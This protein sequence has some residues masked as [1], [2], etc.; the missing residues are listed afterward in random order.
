MSVSSLEDP[1]SSEPKPIP[2]SAGTLAFFSR[3]FRTVRVYWWMLACI[4]GAVLVQVA[5]RL[6]L[7]LA[8]QRLIDDA[9]L[10]KEP[11]LVVLVSLL[12]GGWL[13]QLGAS[14]F[15]DYI[16]A[17]MW[18]K[19]MN[20]LRLQLFRQIQRLSTSFFVRTDANQL[21][22]RFADDLLY[23]ENVY[24]QVIF[25]VILNTLLVLGGSLLLMYLEWQLALLALMVLPIALLMPRILGFSARRHNRAHETCEAQVAAIMRES[26]DGNVVVRTLGLQ[27]HHQTL[28]QTHLEELGNKAISSYFATFRMERGAAQTLLLIQLIVIGIGSYFASFG[29]LSLGGLVAFGALY[30]QL[31]NSVS[32]LLASRILLNR[33]SQGL[34]RLDEFLAEEPHASQP[35]VVKPVPSLSRALNLERICFG[36]NGHRT[37]LENL[38]LKLLAGESL[39]IVGPKGSGKSSVLNLVLR[40]Y[41]P[42]SGRVMVDDVELNR[43]TEESFRAQT[44]VVTQQTFLFNTSFHNNI[45][46]GKLDATQEE[47]VQA[48]REAEIH[49]TIMA[50]PLQY[51]TQVGD[52]GGNLSSEQRQRVALARALVREPCLL[53]LD[54]VTS[55]L[56]QPSE[57]NLI[58]T[59]VRVSRGRTVLAASHRLAS[60]SYM[61]RILVM[62][63]GRFV[64]EGTHQELLERRGLY[65]RMWQKQSGFVFDEDGQFAHCTPQRLRAI[66]LLANLDEDHLDTVAAMLVSEYYPENRRVVVQG[67]PGDKFFIIVHGTVEVVMDREGREEQITLLDE[68]DYFGELALLDGAPRNATVRTKVPTI[69]LSFGRQQFKKLL[70]DEPELR[71]VIEAKAR[72]RRTV[73]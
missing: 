40:L 19:V 31:I 15:Q 48:A 72:F 54:E 73:G 44:G 53:V 39:A 17:R 32:Y 59:L 23:V 57:N 55:S 26:I 67:D 5:F 10:A 45:R 46:M 68:G 3:T 41:G 7:P 34:R 42:Y 18:A 24:T 8:Y 35:A 63:Q 71:T 21:T 61:D 58:K 43:D 66:P 20:D 4:L 49:D 1:V 60:V 47:I 51:D 70:A 38:S 33:G 37:A 27:K 22:T 2:I 6:L 13:I 62:D 14:F 69:L 65:Y 25:T 52:R 36:Y 16:A 12:F 28:F 29:L 50:L 56:D 64:E 9:I 30:L 11:I